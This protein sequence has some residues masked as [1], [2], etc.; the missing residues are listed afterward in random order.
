[1]PRPKGPKKKQLNL[2]LLADTFDRITSDAEKRGYDSP[3]TMVA[4]AV[5]K[6]WGT[7]SVPEPRSETPV[8][9]SFNFAEPKDCSH[10]V[11]RR[12]G[13]TC[14]MCGKEVGK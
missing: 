7:P 4:E 1:M 12:I 6:K 11:G 8:R 2:S 14:A 10:P 13:K 3:A 9:R 5:E